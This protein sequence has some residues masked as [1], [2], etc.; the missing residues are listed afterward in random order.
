MIISW[1]LPLQQPSIHHWGL[2]LF[3][4]SFWCPLK[5]Q[6]TLAQPTV[7]GTVPTVLIWGA[8]HPILQLQIPVHNIVTGQVVDGLE[9]LPHDIR[10]GLLAVDLWSFSGQATCSGWSFGM[11]QVTVYSVQ[12]TAICLSPKDIYKCNNFWGSWKVLAL[13]DTSSYFS[14]RGFLL[15]PK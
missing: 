7:P 1:N 12:Y 9:H 2:S 8:I 4:S 6:P 13:G 11:S 5:R 15:F 3:I 14:N 10:R